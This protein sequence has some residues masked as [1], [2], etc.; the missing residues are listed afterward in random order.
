MPGICRGI[1][2]AR[3]RAKAS[4]P[5]PGANPTVNL[6]VLPP[7]WSAASKPGI[8]GAEVGVGAGA[9]PVEEEELGVGVGGLGVGVG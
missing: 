1:W 7:K 2:T 9:G 5:P 6:M 3:I 4:K 8:A